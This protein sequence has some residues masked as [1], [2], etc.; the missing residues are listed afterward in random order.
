MAED[1]EIPRAE[2]EAAVEGAPGYGTA[3]LA[4]VVMMGSVTVLALLIYLLMVAISPIEARDGKPRPSTRPAP[5]VQ[6]P[7][8]PPP[9]AVPAK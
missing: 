6:A 3:L 8:A 2:Q 4:V 5:A 7:D 1:N 9:P